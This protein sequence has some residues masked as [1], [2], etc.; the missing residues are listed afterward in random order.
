[1]SR[2]YWDEKHLKYFG[3][4]WAGGPSI[5]S[6]YALQFFPKNGRILDIGTGQGGDANFFQSLGY[7]VVATDFSAEAL[8]KAREEVKNVKFLN[9]DTAQGLPFPDETFDIVY[10]HM[11]LH[12]F[13]KETT[14]KIFKDIHRVLKTGGIFATI[15]NTMDD[16]EKDEA[17]YIELEP[18]FY[19]NR[20]I[21]KRYFS[22]TSMSEFT[23][24]LFTTIILDN[25]GEAYK[26]KIKKLIR[27]VGKKI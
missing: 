10:S 2:A 21:T 24:D 25:Q 13:D 3:K 11:A 17:D 14:D 22:I 6:K 8:K 15:A 9:L 4:E 1:M 12:Y 18:G 7:E 5:F 16:G 20:N 23:K 26:D 27:F 19:K